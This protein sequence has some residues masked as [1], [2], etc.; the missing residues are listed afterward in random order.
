MKTGELHSTAHLHTWTQGLMKTTTTKTRGRSTTAQNP[1]LSPK[2]KST[3]KTRATVDNGDMSGT[4]EGAKSRK[5]KCSVCK[6][7][8]GSKYKLQK[9]RRVHMGEEPFR[10]SVCKKEFALRSTLKRHMITHTQGRN[11]SAVQ[12]VRRGLLI[13]PLSKHI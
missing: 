13:G 9:H 3:P 2:Y 10:C 4:G 11:H 7:R 12:S 5:H 1:H 6:E 8:F